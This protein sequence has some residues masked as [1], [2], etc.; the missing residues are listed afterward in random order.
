M[1]WALNYNHPQAV[2]TVE[3]IRLSNINVKIFIHISVIPYISNII[4]ILLKLKL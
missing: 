2:A 4:K 3:D 1:F